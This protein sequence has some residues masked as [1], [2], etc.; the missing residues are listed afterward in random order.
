M[1][2]PNAW[3][4][5]GK[6]TASAGSS[7]ISTSVVLAKETSSAWPTFTV[8]KI[9]TSNCL[10]DEILPLRDGLIVSG[11]ALLTLCSDDM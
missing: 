11:I 6:R 1:R 8:S 9:I 3:T 4:N 10:N 7:S 5:H 2:T